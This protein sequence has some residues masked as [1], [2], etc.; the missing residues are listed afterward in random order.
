[1]AVEQ[2]G[3]GNRYTALVSREDYLA[4]DSQAVLSRL[5]GSSP[6]TLWR[7]WPGEA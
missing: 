4:Y 7:P 3:R 2:S 6:A 1:M 5:Y